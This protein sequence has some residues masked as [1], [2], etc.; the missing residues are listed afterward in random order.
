MKCPVCG[1]D[2]VVAGV[3]RRGHPVCSD[4]G[5]GSWEGANPLR[6]RRL[7]DAP[8]LQT[9]PVRILGLLGLWCV[10]LVIVFGAWGTADAWWPLL[11]TEPSVESF[12]RYYWIGLAVYL[13][14]C[15][16]HDPESSRFDP[17]PRWYESPEKIRKRRAMAN[18]LWF[19]T[20]PGRI[21]LHTFGATWRFVTKP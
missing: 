3:E 9:T 2:N 5:W 1:G 4:C 12:R 13:I 20:L 10:S 8:W 15:W 21:I 14:A 18:I 16:F 19:I 6:K 7:R 17:Y 11:T